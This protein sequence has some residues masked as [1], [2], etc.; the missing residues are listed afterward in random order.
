MGCIQWFVMPF[1]L[2][3]ASDILMC[4]MNEVLSLFIGKFVVVYFHDI[5]VHSQHE[6]LHVEQSVP[7]LEEITIIC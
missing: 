2:S 5:L 3:N 7:S 4:L 1:S 6:A